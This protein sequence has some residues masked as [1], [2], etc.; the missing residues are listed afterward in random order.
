MET[1]RRRV[2]TSTCQTLDHS[3]HVKRHGTGTSEV[4]EFVPDQ[5]PRIGYV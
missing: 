2:H 3:F 4:K 1:E 5:E